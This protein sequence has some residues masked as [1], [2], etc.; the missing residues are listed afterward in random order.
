[1]EEKE[2]KRGGGGRYLLEVG[3]GWR[4]GKGSGRERR[5]WLMGDL[6][7]GPQLAH[8][9][10]A[11][12]RAPSSLQHCPSTEVPYLGPVQRA[13]F[14]LRVWCR[15]VER[16]LERE[17]GTGHLAPVTSSFS[18]VSIQ[19]SAVQLLGGAEHLVWISGAGYVVQTR[20]LS[21]SCSQWGREKLT[22]LRLWPRTQRPR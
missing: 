21:F 13:G 1:M 2:R 14:R 6:R 22:A 12:H 8:Q 5:D 16:R 3:G 4:R 7:Q 18:S 19:F 15:G 10:S 9:S 11:E 17:R 20:A